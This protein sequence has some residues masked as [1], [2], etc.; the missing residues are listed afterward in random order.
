M[1]KISVITVCYNSAKT[2]GRT[3]RSVRDQDWPCVEHIVIDGGSQ[4]DTLQILDQ[5][6]SSLTYVVSE[7]DNGIYDAMNKGVCRATGDVICFL[8]SDDHYANSRVLSQ[9]ATDMENGSLDALFGDI[10]FF[11]ESNPNQIVR[12]YRS[13]FFHPRHLAWGWMPAHPAFF[14]RR[15]FYDRLGVFKQDYHIAGDFEFI[16]RVFTKCILHYKYIPGVVVKMQTGGASTASGFKGRILHNQELLR[17]C[18][19]N[20]ISTN[21]FKILSRYPLKLKEL[22]W[23]V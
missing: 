22:V 17:A 14:L 2:L 23:K 19:E 20:G 6:S 15:H 18:R 3:L 1:L 11:K 21:I 12:H 7:Q 5:F 13:G 8:N 4:D 10:A 9:V 16:A